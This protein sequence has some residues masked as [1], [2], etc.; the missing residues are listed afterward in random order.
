[1]TKRIE[2]RA[3]G[4]GASGHLVAGLDGHA[5]LDASPVPMVLND[6]AGH[7]V[8]AN[9]ALTRAVGYG[10]SDMPTLAAW[11]AQV[12]PDPDDRA[13]V[14]AEWEGRL[15]AARETGAPFRPMEVCVRKADGDTLTMLAASADLTGAQNGLHLVTLTDI[16]P[17]AES[18]RALQAQEGTHQ[19][20]Q[21][22]A[23]IGSFAMGRDTETFTCSQETLRLF[24][25]DP[26][27]ATT[28]AEGFA[29]VHPDDQAAV[30]AA[31]RAALQGAPYEMTYRIVARG[32]QLWIKAHAALEFD[33]QGQLAHGVGTV[34]DITEDV[35]RAAAQLRKESALLDMAT[36]GADLG[37]WYWPMPEG[38]LVWSD[39]CKQM[40]ALPADGKP[41]FEY[42]LSIL[43]PDD[44]E[45]VQALLQAAVDRRGPYR[46]EYRI[47]LP[48]GTVRWI[49][50]PGR[51]FVGPE[52][53]PTGMGGVLI[54]IT[55]R[56]RLEQDLEHARQVLNEA[57]QIAH[58]GSFEYL[59]ARQSISW[60]EEQFRIH[61]LDPEGPAP[62]YAQLVA[63]LVHPV[64]SDPTERAFTEAVQAGRHFDHEYRIAH[65]DGTERWVHTLAY[66]E[67]RPNGKVARYVGTTLDIT[68]RKRSEAALAESE[69]LFRLLTESSPLALYVTG[70]LA[71]RAEYINP[72]FVRLFGY[73]I[74]EVPSVAEWWP[75]AYPDEAYRRQVSEE[76]NRRVATALD[77][78][79]FIEPMEVI[80][81]CKDG[82]TKAIVWGFGAG[83]H[84]NFA[85]GLDVTEHRAALA[86][87]EELAKE[88]RA[89][90]DNAS[91]G[92]MYLKDRN[93]SWCNPRLE[94]M[95]GYGIDELRGLP[96]S[97]FYESGS[98]AEY[99]R[100]GEAAREVLGRGER[101]TGEY[102]GK[103]KDGTHFH[104]QL[105]A[106]TIDPVHPFAGVIACIEDITE[107][108]A[109]EEENRRL[110]DIITEAPDFIGTAT[111]DGVP[112]YLNAAGRR[113]FGL[114]PD[115]PIHASVFDAFPADMQ[116][117][118]LQ[119]ILP[120]ALSQGYW[121][122]DAVLKVSDSQ[123]VPVDMT[124]VAHHDATGKPDRHSVIIRDISDRKR[125]EAA[126]IAVQ[127]AEQAS[128]TKTQF[129][130]AASH[131]LRQ[132]LQALS[133]Y[134]DALAFSKLDQNQRDIVGKILQ[135]T[136]TLGHILNQLLDLSK[137]DGGMVKAEPVAV[138]AKDLLVT[139]DKTFAPLAAARQ[140]SLDVFA[141]RRCPQVQ[142][143][144]RLLATLL[145]NLV[146][147][148][149]KYTEQGGIL[150]SIRRHAGRALVQVW[151]T[152]IGI[153]ED[154]LDRIFEEFTQ[155]NNPERD[156][157]KG[158]GLGLSIVK[159]LAT[160]MD[161]E[162]R[163]RSRPGTGSVFSFSLPLPPA[164]Q[165]NEAGADSELKG[166]PS[167]F[168]R[169]RVVL[170]EDDTEVAQAL[171]QG[172]AMNGIQAL[173]FTS[174]EAA[175]ASREM[176]EADYFLCDFRLP[177]MDGLQFL[178][179]LQEQASGPIRAVL[180]SGES[181]PEQVARVQ[182]AGW[183]LLTKPI[184]LVTLL[185]A[186]EQR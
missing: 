59:P 135:S 62:S 112:T 145:R 92:I 168:G 130:A 165:A 16:S 98:E 120:I 90:L 88:Q 29:R 58:L 178:E 34:Q 183:P 22:V 89:I 103:R 151:D 150:V 149:V 13:R 126:A 182:A 102:Q 66:P 61:G 184:R 12:C 94:Q 147:N 162:I 148:A 185:A 110:A 133:F 57:Q 56:K 139:I 87:V 137:L 134:A 71:Q 81:T 79:G 78:G 159:R 33:A 166:T 26:S 39:R 52:G 156:R 64:D 131:D 41:S 141:S 9:P 111:N 40:L 163:C 174:A 68:D 27:G 153:A 20:A 119:E 3:S 80:V 138:S 146:G 17:V 173:H 42:W 21:A 186:L 155:V 113:M 82:S 107:R 45:R 30:E 93:I 63:R 4:S 181:S 158:Y 46:A 14:T 51:V 6:D 143:D 106:Q 172:L 104:G 142:A 72:A 47:V 117:R 35:E 109:R 152:G 179:R 180:V 99:L 128:A 101:W 75:L 123:T 70:N 28:F 100:V 84:K 85:F 49:F 5:I 53:E 115:D 32:R 91:V 36:D 124:L 122:G 25:L 19:H 44:R 55:E 65:P 2:G 31:W 132:P 175:L 114:G 121:R 83:E 176:H 105:S 67:M 164:D 60:S 43:H 136:E 140:L 154:D 169:K 108:K 95:L 129:L 144:P 97:L 69:R 24:D 23:R 171:M 167:R 96:T 38:D 76:W 118:W 86:R 170:V 73:T 177:G 116:V 18:R 15:R 161:T 8:Y 157:R 48:D 1:M 7:I 10:P 74:E 11:F 77:K 160:L 54:D 125:A 37:L 127:V 50:A